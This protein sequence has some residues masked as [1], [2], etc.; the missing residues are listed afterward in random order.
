MAAV[1]AWA[2]DHELAIDCL[3]VAAFFALAVLSVR[4]YHD[5]LAGGPHDFRFATAIALTALAD[6]ADRFTAADS[7]ASPWSA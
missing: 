2:R 4:T 5:I 6:S 1:W 7:A 3:L